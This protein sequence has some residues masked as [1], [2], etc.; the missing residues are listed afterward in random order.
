MDNTG[1]KSGMYGSMK[2]G[3]FSAFCQLCGSR[4]PKYRFDYPYEK[5]CVNCGAIL[6]PWENREKR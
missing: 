2:D 5:I 6:V 4:C 3:V 1:K